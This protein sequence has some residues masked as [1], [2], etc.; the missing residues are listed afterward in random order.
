M[1][2][3]GEDE[4]CVLAIYDFRSK[5]EY[6][7]RTN[8]MREIT[9]ASEIIA[10]MFG[11]F[12]NTPVDG[13]RIRNDWRTRPHEP[14]QIGP[15]ELGVVVYEGGGNLLVLFRKFC[16]YR[17]ANKVFSR[18]VLEQAHSLVMTAAHVEWREAQTFEANRDRLL[19]EL[20]RKNRVA[21]TGIP[22]NVLPFTLVDRTTFM[23][24][25]KRDH[26]DFGEITREEVLKLQAFDAL[27]PER[28][29]EGKFIDELGTK[30]GEDS[31]VAVIYFD[32]NSIGARVKDEVKRE[33][34]GN[35]GADELCV[36]RDFSKRLHVA[37]VKNVEKAMKE[38]I[39][40]LGARLGKKARGYRVIIDH[41]DEITFICNAHAAPFALDAYFESVRDS[42]FK[43]CAGMAVCHSHDPFAEV[44]KIAEQCCESGKKLNRKNQRA[45]MKDACAN[46]GEARKAALAVDACYVDFHVIRAGITGSLE[47]I[48][49]AQDG[50]LLARPYCV[51]PG[52]GYDAFLYIGEKLVQSDIT[53]S[54]VMALNRAILRGESWYELEKARIAAKAPEAMGQ[55]ANRA[56][57][58]G[59][60]LKKVLFDV[61]SM[62]DVYDLR[63]G[64]DLAGG[65]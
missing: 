28:K 1:V 30:K 62:W 53:T 42:G 6:I 36:M 24:V 29:L 61:S 23:P 4:R 58:C 56:K 20:E 31:L 47:Q 55:I 52:G 16:E 10:G 11:K 19:N 54:D 39:D 32:G 21:F 60:D 22:C 45:A 5:Q 43:A 9:G 46:E 50:D 12:L 27:P 26:R 3:G 65:E 37:L 41:G 13:K 40:G 63:F 48:R 2:D 8:R 57:S 64:A 49:K 17:A 44:Y 25:V 59:L 38:A 7:Y 35:G 15:D 33:C 51:E 18:M 34:E 14:L